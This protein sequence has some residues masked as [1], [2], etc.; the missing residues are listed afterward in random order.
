MRGLA[1]DWLH[2]NHRM[3]PDRTRETRAPYLSPG[4]DD[5]W[6]S[7]TM[8]VEGWLCGWC[9][10]WGGLNDLIQKKNEEGYV[11]NEIRPEGCIWGLCLDATLNMWDMRSKF[12]YITLSE[13][14]GDGWRYK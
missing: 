4:F 9:G 1:A 8:D 5:F 7:I 12:G 2:A 3:Q 14:A 6:E 10:L 13:I 11:M